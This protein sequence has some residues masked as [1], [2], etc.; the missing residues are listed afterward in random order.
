V[1]FCT[2][3]VEI[4]FA[5]SCRIWTTQLSRPTPHA[6]IDLNR[7]LSATRLCD[8]PDNDGLC[9]EDQERRLLQTE[10]SILDANRPAKGF[11]LVQKVGHYEG[12]RCVH[13]SVGALLRNVCEGAVLCAKLEKSRAQL[14]DASRT[15]LRFLVSDRAMSI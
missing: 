3:T 12:T 13:G 14:D 4:L 7:P 5:L 10:L 8:D 1:D 2:S 15:F 11:P 9:S 6:S